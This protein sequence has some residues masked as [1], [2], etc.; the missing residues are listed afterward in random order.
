MK[1]TVNKTKIIFKNGSR[2]A[3]KKILKNK[4]TLIVC[5]KNGKQR[6]LNDK[7]LKFF[8][9]LKITWLSDV[10]PNPSLN[11]MRK[12]NKILHN[13][14]FDYIL[15]FGGGSTIDTAKTVK[16]LITRNE[17][18]IKNLFKDNLISVK[19]NTR[20]IAIPTTSGTGSEVTSYA[21]IWDNSNKKKLS[22]NL[23]FL[24]PDLAI[25]DPELTYNLP[26]EDTVSTG[27][28]AF[29]Q[30]FE[31]SIWN[32]NKNKKIDKYGKISISYA[33][34][35]LPNLIKN[36]NSKKDRNKMA[37]SSL[38]AGLCISANRTSLCH[39][40]SYPMTANLNMPHG[41]ACAVTMI[42]VIKYIYSKDKFFFKDLIKEL[43]CK[44][45]NQF[46]NTIEKLFKTVQLKNKSKIFIKNKR[47]FL[48]LS[49]EMYTPGRADNFTYPINTIL[50]KQII[51]KTY[52]W[53]N[54]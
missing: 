15:G 35:A 23:N 46:L 7:K 14:K 6:I 38:Y 21:T 9:N 18:T 51:S 30:A 48:K 13:I 32:K 50:I 40:M 39:S 20:L 26:I 10:T 34:H 43:N 52:D 42:P 53:I 27:L 16:V 47:E 31:S 5:T 37:L 8:N 12:I 44:S 24:Y 2:I 17:K 1:N 11:Y 36:K 19:D 25:V 28:D 54:S 49:K 29:N 4:K 22:L 45:Y 3:L 33:L 41:L